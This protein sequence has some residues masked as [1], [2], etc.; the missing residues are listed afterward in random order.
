M[1]NPF[2][3][4]DE[5]LSKNTGHANQA[6]LV[7][8]FIPRSTTKWREVITG[9]DITVGAGTYD[10]DGYWYPSGTSF[11][12]VF[13]T[14]ARSAGNLA[15]V[16]CG[17][18]YRSAG[19]GGGNSARFGMMDVAGNSRFAIRHEIYSRNVMGQIR[20]S[21]GT[22]TGLEASY[23][24]PGADVFGAAVKQN[25]TTQN[26]LTR[27]GG[28]TTA[29]PSGSSTG[30]STTDNALI[31]AGVQ[32]T[33]KWACQY[34]FV[35]DTN[36]SDA[37]INSIID[38]PSGVINVGGA[39]LNLAQSGAIAIAGALAV[40]GQV[41][42]IGQFWR[43]P[44]NIPNGTSV[45]VTIFSGSSP[46]YGIL[47]QGVATVS[48]GFASIPAATGSPGDKGFAFVHNYNDNT[49]TVAINGG[50]GVGTRAA[51]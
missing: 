11:V 9:T 36:L 39:G 45:H 48:G 7:Y 26:A 19:G 24:D 16:V 4:A 27:W 12:D 32:T 2:G 21:S 22:S 49:A 6:N 25:G 13:M 3:S 10:A 50:P 44:T 5:A 38:T 37:N 8:A 46:T 17:S 20:D 28:T 23:T 35:Y 18:K 29:L 1:A 47:A 33:N 34:V 30:L 40:I 15:T 43:V 51:V 42:G 14:I 41:A 31:R